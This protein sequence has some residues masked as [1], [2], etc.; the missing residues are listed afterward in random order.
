M[1][2]TIEK[3]C[4]ECP[5]CQQY[6]L[7][8]LGYGHLAP[9]EARVQPWYEIAVDTIGPWEILIDGETHKFYALTII[10]TVTNLVE[11]TRVA[12]TKAS[13]AATQ[14]EVTWLM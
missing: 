13:D 12:S 8:G 2:A 14:L 4:R 1:H 10:D 11:L 6:K 3:W 5:T 9:R 7:V